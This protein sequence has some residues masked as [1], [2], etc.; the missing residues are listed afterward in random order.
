MELVQLAILIAILVYSIILHEIAHGW[1]AERLGDSTARL[2]GRLTLDPRPHIDLFT[3]II[4]PVL[5]FFLS[6]IIFGAAKPIPI[7]PIN[8][9]DP[10]KDIAL[11][12]LAGP[13]TNILIAVFFAL[14]FRILPFSLFRD[15]AQFNILL[16]VFNLLPFPPLDGF[17]VVG[18]ILPD[19]YARV[20][21]SFERIGLTF[22][23]F[24]LFFFM[25]L[26]NGIVLPV[27]QTIL[28][29]L[30]P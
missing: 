16:A 28:H 23:I 27:S 8:F 24:L 18:G 6:G 21:F 30:L 1:V 5:S 2:R 26:V 14:L 7:N 13:L 25:P 22:I 19:E 12:S 3:T 4:L 29:F 10:K 17:K 20:W 15:A 9:R 11:T